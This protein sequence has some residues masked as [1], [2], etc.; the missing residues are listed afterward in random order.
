MHIATPKTVE[1]HHLT[2]INFGALK[3][4]CYGEVWTTC[5]PQVSNIFLLQL[6]SYVFLSLALAW[7]P[8]EFEN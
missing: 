7:I 8:Q 6:L 1:H 2:V 3:L 4:E 5:Y